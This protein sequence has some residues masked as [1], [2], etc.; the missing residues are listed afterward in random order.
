M[1]EFAELGAL[2]EQRWREQNYDE[3]VFPE[4]AATALKKA[5]LP[6]K[7]SAW[8]VTEWAMRQTHLPEQQDLHASFGEP[9]ITLFNS[10]RFHIDIYFWLSSTTAIHQHGFCG[11][12]QVLL[13]G[14]LHCHYDFEQ[15]SR[16]NFHC[17]TGNINLKSVEWLKPGDIKA[18]D[19][20]KIYIHSL[21]HLENPSAT[22]VVRTNSVPLAP[23]QFSY[24]KP[25]LALDPFFS[26]ATFIKKR[27]IVRALINA[28]A[29]NADKLIVE[30][31]ESSDLHLTIELLQFLQSN[32]AFN[33][34]DADSPQIIAQRNRFD[35]FFQTAVN[36]HEQLS[37]ILPAVFEQ[38][39][40]E[41]EIIRRRGFVT[42][43]N[44]RYFLALLL[45]VTGKTRILSL[46]KERV[47][48]QDP[49]ETVLDWVDE[50]GRT[51]ITGTNENALGIEDYSDVHAF[52]LEGMLRDKIVA[53]IKAEI[54]A[55]AASN[56][57]VELAAKIPQ[58]YSAL[59]NS[60]LFSS[61][62]RE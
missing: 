56:E 10:S 14:S 41:F 23:P 27:Q 46:I 33:R 61:L 53:E 35:K 62:W 6:S 2:V 31:I 19:A 44:H 54:C 34:G 9:P 60:P 49:I 8:D 51:R 58:Y 18:I 26:D 45:N 21:F 16:V 28:R 12:F 30:M 17:A 24:F 52:V 37:D 39:E 20:G 40:R 22:V 3:T 5:N 50:L 13:G 32:L 29:A 38:Q 4:I 7:I 42:D 57:T 15:H 25:S 43:A 11:A 48:D 36:R 55:D 59:E 47:S 1:K